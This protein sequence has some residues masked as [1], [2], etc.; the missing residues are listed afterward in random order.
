MS[1]DI[2]LLFI[3]NYLIGS[4]PFSYIIGR[5]Y[6]VDIRKVGS[7]NVGATNVL[8]TCGKTAGA[9]AYFFDISKGTASALLTT[10][11][12]SR[13]QY[14]NGEISH[15]VIAFVIFIIPVFGHVFTVFLKFKGGKGVA[16]SAGIFLVLAPFGVLI[17]L[18]VFFIILKLTKTVSIS[19]ICAACIFPNFVFF[20]YF[21]GKSASHF[22]YWH[23]LQE[24]Y[25]DS[26]CFAAYFIA[27]IIVIL[28]REN[29]RRFLK[30]EE[31]SFGNNKNRD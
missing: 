26:F 7:G 13:I 8:R 12:L 9:L 31:M 16:T 3:I 23:P 20:Q 17:S 25:P 10:F 28:H 24:A 14:F 1:L 21:F 5:F 2:I 30:G 27:F 15:G 19:S 4:I 18:I 29:L 6:G 22:L 11:Y